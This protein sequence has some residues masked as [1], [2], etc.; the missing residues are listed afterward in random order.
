MQPEQFFTT[1]CGAPLAANTAVNKDIGIYHQNLTP[2]SV[3]HA[4]KKSSAPPH[5]LAVSDTH[6]FTAQE[7]KAHVHVYSRAKGN[8]ECFVSFPERIRCIALIGHVLVLGTV[9]GRL[10]LWEVFTGRQVITPACHVQGI[11]CLAVT[12]YHILSGSDDANVNV[13]SLARLLELDNQAELE[14][15]QILSNHRG[16]ITSLAISPSTN[17][18][19]NLCVSASKDKTCIIWNYQSGQVLR[20]L[21]FPAAPLCIALD[22]A[23]RAVTAMTESGDLFCVEFFGSAPILGSRAT[24]QS[25]I[26]MQV[27]SPLGNANDE[28][29]AANC[30]AM[31]YD[32]TC[33]LTG[34]AKGKIM[35][36]T[37]RES[38]HPTEIASLNASVTNLCFIPRATE[39]IT[40][41]QQA[42]IKPHMSQRK[43]NLMAQI[44]GHATTESRFSKLS[45]GEGFSGDVLEEAIASFMNERE[46]K[47]GEAVGA[48]DDEMLRAI[49]GDL[50]AR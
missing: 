12:P 48:Y 37:L 19:T 36:W 4:F 26:V 25:S 45:S 50:L 1:V 23:S 17:P 43:Y 2:Y 11:S 27:K 21:L 31:S 30:I 9:E 16:A 29:G 33:V 44:A 42:V 47:S 8:Q 35:R 32:G 20:T 40:P 49:M 6:V 3:S 18:E 10:I 15:E 39:K 13:W 22:P 41:A 14:P 24:E 38:E 5:C 7:N 34:H 28:A 46:K